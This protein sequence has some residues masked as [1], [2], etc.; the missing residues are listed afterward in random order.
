[1]TRSQYALPAGADRSDPRGMAGYIRETAKKYGIDPEVAIRVA[2]SEGLSSFRSGVRTKSGAE[3]P[4]FGAFQLYTGGGLGNQF[5]K[6]TGLDPS[7]PANEKATIDYAL[8][9]AAKVGWGPWHGAKNTGI[10]QW[11]GIGGAGT[12]TSSGYGGVGSDAAASA[13]AAAGSDKIKGTDTSTETPQVAQ[14]GP[15][16]AAPADD[17][18]SKLKNPKGGAS[19]GLGEAISGLG[20]ALTGASPS[21]RGNMYDTAPSRSTVPIPVTP[22]PAMVPMVDPRAAEAQRQQLAAAMQRLNTGRLY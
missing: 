4:S 15:A 9:T 2:K 10:K 3:E 1:M 8:K 14:S 16:A 13:R 19:E 5:R 11:E 12:E 22:T 20:A 6:E 18:L 7:D 21:G 17:L